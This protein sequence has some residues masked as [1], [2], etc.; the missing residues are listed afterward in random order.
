[1][2][3]DAATETVRTTKDAGAGKPSGSLASRIKDPGKLFDHSPKPAAASGVAGDYVIK[4][5][6]FR[7][8][9]ENG[10]SHDVYP[11]GVVTL[12]AEEHGYMKEQTFVTPDGRKECVIEAVRAT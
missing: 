10:Q 4:H 12:T 2:A 8:G 5:G 9:H 7:L 3:T 1:M 11:G 6:T